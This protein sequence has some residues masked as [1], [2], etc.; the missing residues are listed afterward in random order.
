MQMY[1]D[2]LNDHRKASFCNGCDVLMKLDDGSELPAHLQHLARASG[3]CKAMIDDGVLSGT[4]TS[5][6]AILPLTDCSR[7]TAIRLLSALYSKWPI[8]HVTKE[9][10]EAISSVAHKLD[11]KVQL[12]V[13]SHGYAIPLVLSS[14]T[15]IA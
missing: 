3:L 15:I 7:A 10:W 4:T 14:E 13:L 1:I 2:Y 9:S 6:K 5:E 8:Q 11:M 12:C